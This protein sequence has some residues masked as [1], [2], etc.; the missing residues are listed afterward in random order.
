METVLCILPFNSQ[1]NAL[2]M[3]TSFRIFVCT[4]HL[5]EVKKKLRRYD[6]KA[7]IFMGI[8][9]RNWQKTVLGNGTYG[10]IES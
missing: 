6:L 9:T 3:K 7:F 8:K 1:K 2:T 5:S 4:K 10:I